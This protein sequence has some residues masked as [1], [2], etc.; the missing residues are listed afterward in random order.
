[1]KKTRKSLHSTALKEEKL[2]FEVDSHLLLELGERLVARP[3][4]A[5][6]ELVKN[7]Y[8]A[9]STSATIRFLDV[10]NK[11]GTIIVED[12]GEGMT[13]LDLKAK[14][15]RIG[16]DDK[17][18]NPIS[19]KYKR[20]RTGRKGI[21][22]FA[23]RLI[24][25]KLILESV[26]KKEDG[27]KEKIR[28]HFLWDQLRP[29]REVEDFKVDVSRE[30]VPEST[31]TGT[32]LLLQGTRLPWSM[33][34][35]KK[36]KKEIL[37][38]VNPFP[39][40]S[41][42]MPLSVLPRHDPGFKIQVEAPDYP[43]FEGL[44]SD[45]ILKASWG[46]LE[47]KLDEDGIPIYNLNIT[48][49]GERY[50]FRPSKKYKELGSTSFTVY[51]FSL[52]ELKPKI[53]GMTLSALRRLAREYGGV[54]V[55]LDGFRVFR[56][57]EPG[58]DWLR[59]E[60]DRSRSLGRT[61]QALLGE[62]KG[63]KRPMLSIPGNNQLFGA[64]FLSRS[65][66]P[67]ISPTVT[68]DRLLE[69]LAFQQLR[70]FVRLGIDW[71]TVKYAAYRARE[72]KKEAE[73]RPKRNALSTINEIEKIVDE[74][75]TEIGSDTVTTLQQYV[76]M[77]KEDLIRQQEESM[78]QIAMLRILAS[79]GTMITVFDHEISL[80]ARRLGE[81]ASDLQGFLRFIPLDEKELFRILLANTRAW[82]MNVKRL[83]S[84]IG[85]MLGK[86]ARAKK[87]S[88]SIHKAVDKIFAPFL[89]YMNENHIRPLNDV[90]EFS[91][92]PPMYEAE[93]Q[94]ILVN[95]MTNAIKALAGVEEKKICVKVEDTEDSISILFLDTGSGLPRERW[96]KA[97][98]PFVSY[99]VPSLDFGLGT[100]LGLAIVNDIVESYGGKVGFVDPPEGWSTCV[101]IDMPRVE[102]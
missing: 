5:L 60:F 27:G 79:T 3:S 94:S 28:A 1:M 8:D 71:I 49:T 53:P 55:F 38:L 44:L 65:Q 86:D 61:P 52:G 64:V 74:H 59:L 47:G 84:I 29:G 87:T 33:E 56:Y 62:A 34:N 97:F 99:S 30:V 69:N 73:M 40:R 81:M 50:N 12:N 19:P 10:H 51:M 92:T 70:D 14:W 93:L 98:E 41:K 101:R 58:D 89:R 32:R 22:R 36:F 13:F 31:P 21:G 95:L 23:C 54:K 2:H 17:V 83:A 48:P 11:G 35:L 6:A 4:I 72:R 7:S 15:M 77:A 42:E 96:E 9:D 85:L 39:W 57:G 88:L 78:S 82:Q 43:L 25:E 68:R 91:R 76:G 80:A 46:R 37:G 18:R 45:D 24:S 26:S 67:E 63:L 100:G 75:S 16:T 102:E 66:N 90:S 20:T